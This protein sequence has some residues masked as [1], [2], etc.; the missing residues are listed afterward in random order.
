MSEP[1]TAPASAPFTAPATGGAT[2]LVRRRRRPGYHGPAMPEPDLTRLLQRVN[3]GDAAASEQLFPLVYQELHRLARQ[4]MARERSDH[5]LQPTALLHEA[6]LKLAG[7]AEVAVDD[8][9]HFFRL[10]ARAMRNVLVDH[11]R[12]RNAD[13]RGGGA[14]AQ[15]LEG[16]L[17][18]YEDR[19]VDVL[20]LHEALERLEQMDAPLARVVELRWFA[21][22]SNPEVAAALDM[23]LRSVERAWFTARAWL[24]TEL[25]PDGGGGT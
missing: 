1:S 5:T 24:R 23:S 14:S 22:F 9:A 15:P 13:K 18:A 4:Q 21:G 19:D 3:D 6:W 25:D 10:A 2:L 16:I 8:R 11:A 7:G 20:A 17:L 12:A